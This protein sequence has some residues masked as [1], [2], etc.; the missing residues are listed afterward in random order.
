MDV[1]VVFK[2]VF[3]QGKITFPLVDSPLRTDVQ[4]DEMVNEEHHI[5]SSPLKN[6]SIGM[7]SQFPLDLM[8][9]VCLGV[10]KHLIWLWMKGPVANMSRIGAN[11]IALISSSLHE[12]TH[13]LPTEF[14]RK[15][16]ALNEMERW[17]AT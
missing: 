13:F 2:V 10:V 6:L 16:R 7:V 12:F 5:G 17:N 15:C 8:H 14:P 3:G 9:L 1:A 11:S 4:F